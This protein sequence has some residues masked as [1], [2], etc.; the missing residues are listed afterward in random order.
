VPKPNPSECMLHK[1]EI[2]ECR[3]GAYQKM[4]ARTIKTSSDQYIIKVY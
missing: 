3:G 1:D 2:L 4:K